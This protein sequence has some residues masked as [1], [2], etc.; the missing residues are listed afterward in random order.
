MPFLFLFP[1]AVLISSTE[2]RS[3]SGIHIP[4]SERSPTSD[5]SANGITTHNFIKDA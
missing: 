2:M 5:I 1:L 4:Q 3:W